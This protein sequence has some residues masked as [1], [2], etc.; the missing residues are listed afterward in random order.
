LLLLLL[1]YS[2]TL[3]GFGEAITQVFYPDFDNFSLKSVL[4]ALGHVFFSLGLGFGVM[5][6]Y[7]A[8]LPEDVSLMKV[9]LWVVGLDTLAGLLAAIIIYSLLISGEQNPIAGPVLMFQA[10]P[11]VLDI[12]PYSQ[13]FTMLLFIVL[14]L[15]AW[16]TAIA[17][18]EPA[19]A[20]LMESH[21][22]NRFQA[23]LWIGI[24]AWLLGIVTIL[25]FNYWAFDFNFFGIEKHLGIFDIL[26]IWISSFLLPVAGMLVPLYVGWSLSRQL[27][28]KAL[29][30]RHA[31]VFSIWYWS[32]R[33]TVPLLMLILM[34]SIPSLFL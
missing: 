4:V 26:Q 30:F 23:S 32:V 34:F 17:L 29:K 6:M 27:T 16:M 11:L 28:E 25:S 10:I 13:F 19:M 7:G 22:M 5:L 33:V 24:G 3:H 21:G 8:Y 14:V 1:A 9:S 18:I 12:L 31:R 15:A 2:V 20:W